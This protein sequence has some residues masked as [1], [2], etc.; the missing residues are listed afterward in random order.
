[1]KSK[2]A[3]FQPNKIGAG[4][5]RIEQPASS[6][7]KHHQSIRRWR[8]QRIPKFQWFLTGELCQGLT[9]IGSTTVAT[10]CQCQNGG[11][12]RARMAP[13]KTN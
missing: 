12:S 3:C 1:M 4:Q 10:G 5:H 6:K 9:W 8:C 13:A 11:L 7:C 2:I